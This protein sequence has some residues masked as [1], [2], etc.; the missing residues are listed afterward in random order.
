VKLS[1]IVFATVFACGTA[2]LTTGCGKSKVDQCNSFVAEA[3][4][5]QSAFVAISAAMLNPPSLVPRAEKLDA[6]VKAMEALPLKDS[7]LDGFR[8]QYIEYTNT[9]A[10]G[11]R[12]IASFGKDKTKDAERDKVAKELDEVG[13]KEGKLID[14]INAYCSDEKLAKAPPTGGLRLQRVVRNTTRYPPGAPKTCLSTVQPR[15]GSARVIPARM[16]LAASGGSGFPRCRRLQKMPASRSSAARVL[17]ASLGTLISARTY[18]SLMRPLVSVSTENSM[19]FGK[20]AGPGV[21][22]S[23]APQP[24]EQT[25]DGRQANPE[26][27]GRRGS[28]DH[29]WQSFPPGLAASLFELPPRTPNPFASPAARPPPRLRPPR[30]TRGGPQQHPAAKSAKA[31]A[32]KPRPSC[33][34]G[35]PSEDAATRAPRQTDREVTTPS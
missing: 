8:K 13:D 15:A 19:R 12:Q 14:E 7:K 28:A 21:V 3:N 9:F 2:A 4:K 31:H 26:V 17:G 32:S 24:H 11:L 29:A 1:R 6:S 25:P 35:G 33:V 16:A 34:R 27:R 10:K 30:R 18:A 20:P 5:S 22:P 23:S